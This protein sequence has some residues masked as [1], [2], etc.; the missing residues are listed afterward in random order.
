MSPEPRDLAEALSHE[1]DAAAARP[2]DL[3]T[4]LRA[5]RARRRARR[6][7]AVGAA[8]SLA[9]LLAVGGLVLAVGTMGPDLAT[10]TADG[11]AVESAEQMQSPASGGPAEPD[12][13]G[14][15][16]D[17]SP[18]A[19]QD[20]AQF[21]QDLEV[22]APETLNACGAPI[23]P[24]TEGA[25]SQLTAVVEPPT[26]T[27]A[28]GEEGEAV[29]R[30]SNEGTTEVVGSLTAP[31]ITVSA[32]GITVWHPD[33]GSRAD[34]V[35]LRLSPGESVTVRGRYAAAAC[36]AGDE[37]AT[38]GSLT[39]LEPGAYALSAA[40]AFTSSTDAA[41]GVLVSPAASVIVE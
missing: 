40:L 22:V 1:A 32:A 18:V 14:A 30:V 5:S 36:A 20:Q 4:V 24:A 6:R 19:P 10:S 21:G 23:A 7:T 35:P 13:G 41:G 29:V 38:G 17:G 31:A 2:V 25:A 26:G 3:G 33:L 39:P 37:A 15:D 8:A 11:P 27:I 9:G 34:A 28:P 12:A 16:A